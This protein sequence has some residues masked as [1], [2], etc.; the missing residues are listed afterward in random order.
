MHGS[1]R[2]YYRVKPL[3]DSCRKLTDRYLYGLSFVNYSLLAAD[4][5]AD[6]VEAVLEPCM[7]EDLYRAFT[8]EPFVPENGRI[9]GISSRSRV[10][11]PFI[12]GTP[13]SRQ[14][15]RT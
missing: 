7:F 3:S 12:L 15:T 5:D 8:R 6:T 13:P 10:P 9:P 1:L 14:P 2:D 11:S 4:W